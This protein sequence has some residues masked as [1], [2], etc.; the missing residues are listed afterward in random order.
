[1]GSIMSSG[2]RRHSIITEI[3]GGILSGN[4]KIETSFYCHFE[5]LFY[6]KTYNVWRVR[7]WQK[8]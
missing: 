4:D 7:L 5:V 8:K 2:M 1:M 6:Y 3:S